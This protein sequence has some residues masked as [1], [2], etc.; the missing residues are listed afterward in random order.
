MIYCSI[1]VF[2]IISHQRVGGW[3][4]GATLQSGRKSEKKGCSRRSVMYILFVQFLISS[5]VLSW[6][7]FNFLDKQLWWRLCVRRRPTWWVS[8]WCRVFVHVS[9]CRSLFSAVAVWWLVLY[10]V[11]FF[12]K[13]KYRW[14]LHHPAN[15]ASLLHLCTLFYSQF[16]TTPPPS[17]LLPGA[18]EETA[19]SK[20]LSWIRRR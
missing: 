14:Q 20:T 18:I 8:I 7:L 13:N 12:V 10:F 19:S 6:S 9:I 4:W 15:G 1:S 11:M 3:G 17:D 2:A 5:F 16:S